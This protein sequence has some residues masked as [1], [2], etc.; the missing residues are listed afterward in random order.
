MTDKSKLACIVGVGET[1]YTRW[2]GIQDRSQF[3]VA[4]EA[5]LAALKDAN[6]TP[7]DVDGFV[8]YSDDTNDA[9]LMQVALGIPELRWTSMLWGGGGGGSCGSISLA[10]AAVESGQANVVVAYRGLCQGQSGRYGRGAFNFVHRNFINPFGMFA[11]VQMLALQTR[12]YMH[13]Y[14]ATSDHLAEIAISTR[15][16]ANRNPSAF[17]YKK[18]LTLEQYY[19]S[20]MISDPFRL[21]DCCLESDGAAAAVITSRERARDMSAKRVDILA[22]GHGSG[23]GWGTG[24]LGSHNMPDEDYASTNGRRIARELY[25]RA[26]ISPDDIDVAEIYDHF[27]GLVL[28]A[29][30]DYGFCGRGEAPAFVEEGNIRWQTGSLPLNTHGGNLSQAYMHGFNHIVEGVR[31]IRGESTSQVQDAKL[32]LVTG[33]LGTAPTSALILGEPK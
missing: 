14:G 28:M 9:C 16:N 19:A 18:P 1:D 3:Q 15:A 4:G 22:S 11:P 24:P 7:A 8:S 29:L 6:L 21:F 25:A 2:G 31:Q 33:G 20:R 23:P 27:T 10:A 30:E 12:R 5:I 17:M 32:C 13:L 26:G